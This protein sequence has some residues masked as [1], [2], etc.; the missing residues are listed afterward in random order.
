MTGYTDASKN[1]N[2]CL[3]L[4]YSTYCSRYINEQ[5]LEA[6]TRFHQF[7]AETTFI[8]MHGISV[9]LSTEMDAPVT[10]AF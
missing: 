1:A 7:A 10:I 8:L 5:T 3:N 2:L 6:G 9:L 4:L